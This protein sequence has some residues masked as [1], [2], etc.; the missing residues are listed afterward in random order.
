[1]IY[2]SD[3]T[4]QQYGDSMLDEKLRLQINKVCEDN[5]AKIKLGGTISYVQ[6]MPWI[7]NCTIRENILF[8]LP[9]NNARYNR[10]IEICQLASD[11]EMLP[12]GDL[13]EIGEKGINL[14]GGQKARV[15]LARAVYADRDIILIDDPVSA[16]DAKVKKKVFEQVFMDELRDK[17]RVLVTHTV[18]FIDRVDRIVIME[19]GLIKYIGIYEDMQHSEEIK[20]I[21]ETLAYKK[22]NDDSCIDEQDEDAKRAEEEKDN[23]VKNFLSLKGTSITEDENEEI[24]DV[25]WSIYANFFLKNGTWVVYTLVL[26]IFI[27]FSYLFASKTYNWVTGFNTVRPKVCFGINSS[28]SYL[29]Y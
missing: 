21:I 2:L 10:T 24:I 15:S 29:L 9:M 5:T 17:I 1:M 22:G 18:D 6:Q 12:G 4:I 8:N 25:G 23:E 11:L 3:E 28:M 20:H 26:Q 16:L 14:S 27:P 13:T 19:S 7:R